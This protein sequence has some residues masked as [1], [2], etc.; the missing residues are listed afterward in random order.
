MTDKQW[1]VFLEFKDEFKKL[2]AEWNKFSPELSFFQS[3]LAE[4]VHYNLENSI[5]YNQDY[6]KIQKSDDIN[7]II[8]GDNPG[9][10]EQLEK[11][12]RY[13]VGQSGRIAEGFFRRNEELNTDF[14]KNIIILNKT[15]VHTPKTIDLKYLLK[16]GSE[17]IKNLIFETQ[18]KM[19]GLAFFL[20]N[21]FFENADSNFPELWL[22]GYS[23]LKRNGIFSKYRDEL[24]N[25]YSGYSSWEKV[26]VYQH[27]SMN[28]FLIDLKEFRKNTNLSLKESLEKIGYLH[29]KE[30]FE[31]C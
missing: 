15:P 9:K 23:E 2:C 26:F 16:N 6:E 4:K 25:C 30:I 12:R 28:R 24:K 19:A 14:R 8:I 10:E 18:I 1:N 22:V 29:K 13:L 20:H 11:N 7:F 17:D 27:F 31:N 21:G 3:Q 5:V